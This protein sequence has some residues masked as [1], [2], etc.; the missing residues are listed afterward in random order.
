MNA[1]EML[2]YYP[3]PELTDWNFERFYEVR[4]RFKPDHKCFYFPFLE[5]QEQVQW[6]MDDGDNILEQCVAIEKG[7][8]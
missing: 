3:M 6:S 4:M 7:W 1:N 8:A 5:G 2:S